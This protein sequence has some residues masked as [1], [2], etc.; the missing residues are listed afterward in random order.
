M[1]QAAGTLL[2]RHSQGRLEVLLIHP[3]GNY[4]RKAPWGIPKGELD[5]G[6]DPEA[7]ARRETW[8]ETGVQAGE[9]HDLGHIEY[10]KSRKRV[11]CFAGPAPSQ[12]QP[13]CASWEVDQAQFVPIEQAY[14]IMHPDQK[15]FLDR[16]KGLLET[17]YSN[18]AT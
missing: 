13:R 11:H 6:E 9:L 17:D 3:S 5:G 12:C 15:A 14:S 4:N 10:K 7:A 18:L 8:E 2:F 16:L 1:K